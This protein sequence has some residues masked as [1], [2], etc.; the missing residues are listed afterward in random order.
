MSTTKRVPATSKTGD[1][2]PCHWGIAILI[3]WLYY[4]RR[5]APDIRALFDV[6][7]FSVKS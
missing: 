3:N 7:Y 4:K 2:R 6:T 1:T 5:A